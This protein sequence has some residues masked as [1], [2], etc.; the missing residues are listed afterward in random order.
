MFPELVER[1]VIVDVHPTHQIPANEYLSLKFC[2]ILK[3]AAESIKNNP[4]QLTLSQARKFLDEKLKEQIPVF[5]IIEAKK[6][7]QQLP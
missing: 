1:L 6:N 2:N 3:E 5:I 7:L 4:G